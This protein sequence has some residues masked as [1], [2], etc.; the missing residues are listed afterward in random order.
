MMTKDRTG[1]ITTA[2][3]SKR[4]I[5]ALQTQTLWKMGEKQT[6]SLDKVPTILKPDGDSK[7]LSADKQTTKLS[8]QIHTARIAKCKLSSDD[9]EKLAKGR[10]MRIFILS[11]RVKGPTMNLK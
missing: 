7:A 5:H 11:G 2:Y 6:V 8:E 3:G 9:V 4:L 10:R 1:D